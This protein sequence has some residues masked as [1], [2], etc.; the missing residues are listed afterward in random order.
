MEKL[1]NISEFRQSCE[2]SREILEQYF[3]G[4]DINESKQNFEFLSIENVDYVERTNGEVHHLLDDSLLDNKTENIDD[5]GVQKYEYDDDMLE[6]TVED[7]DF[8][9]KQCNVTYQ[10]E[11]QL[12]QHIKEDHTDKRNYCHCGL[13]FE[14][15]EILEA[16]LREDKCESLTDL[17]CKYCKHDYPSVEELGEHM[18]EKHECPICRKSYSKSSTLKVHLQSHNDENTFICKI[19]G[20]GF[21]AENYLRKHVKAIHT[22]SHHKCPSCPL[23]FQNKVKFEYHL[24]SHDPSKQFNCSQCNKTFLQMHHRDNH[25]RTHTGHRQFLC[26]ICGKEFAQDT[27]LKLHL[28]LHTGQRPYVCHECGKDFTQRNSFLMHQRYHSGIRPYQCE[29][30]GKDFIQK[31]SLTVHL[32]THT[33]QRPYKCNKCDKTFAQSQQLKS[34]KSTVHGDEQQI[35]D[36]RPKI[37]R[38]QTEDDENMSEDEDRPAIE[39]GK[40]S[41]RK[42]KIL[43]YICSLCNRG[44]RLPSSLSSHMKSHAEERKHI[45]SECGNTFKR[46]EHL[47]IHI[48]GVHL[49]QKPYACEVNILQLLL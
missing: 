15:V 13:M 2:K 48:N 41:G 49:K 38:E 5:D 29:H 26:N 32:R 28:R 39:E 10:E 4:S 30:C 40:S 47:K 3:L 33:G 22:I 46:A 7:D 44:F 1:Y 16:H 14:D 9:C 12:V 17:S 27:G 31:S 37:E 34:H 21:K 8:E 35:K 24:R 23:E 43:P 6:Y 25:E 36:K 20:N 18:R 11:N 45:C 42:V 19:C